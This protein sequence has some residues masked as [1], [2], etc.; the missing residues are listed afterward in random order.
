MS[1]IMSRVLQKIA[2]YGAVAWVFSMITGFIVFIAMSAWNVSAKN[3]LIDQLDKR[4]EKTEAGL[5]VAADT[6]KTASLD[7]ARLKADVARADDKLDTIIEQQG[8]TTGK[9]DILIQMQNRQLNAGFKEW[10][11]PK[12]PQPVYV[13]REPRVIT[14]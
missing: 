14:K 5:E 6:A 10:E 1:R 8:N 7:V 3:Q 12:P 9:L 2:D 11:P 4:F 13:S